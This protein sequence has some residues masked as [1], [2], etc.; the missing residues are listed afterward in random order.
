M[1]LFVVGDLIWERFD[2]FEAVDGFGLI[3][4]FGVLFFIFGNLGSVRCCLELWWCFMRQK[5][6]LVAGQT[7]EVKV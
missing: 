1:I 4:V 6:D 3:G 5:K 2:L 7:I